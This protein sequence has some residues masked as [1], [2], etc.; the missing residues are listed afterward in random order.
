MR[1]AVFCV[2]FLMVVAPS[3][4]SESCRNM[5][6]ARQHFRLAHIYWHG[7]DHCWDASPGRRQRRI[8]HT[9]ARKPDQRNWRDAMS[10]VIPDP[11]V[12]SELAPDAPAAQIVWLD[13]WVD[14]KPAELPPIARG[15]DLLRATLRPPA[16]PTTRSA[17][18]V[19]LLFAL[20]VIALPLAMIGG[21][22]PGMIYRRQS[23]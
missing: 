19:I 10:E 1:V 22:P 3:E 2:L 7:P 16:E 23:E 6:E 11:Q 14:V 13:R 20:L 18:V 17:T 8:V 15:V 5:T 21:L 9:V 4:A 12:A